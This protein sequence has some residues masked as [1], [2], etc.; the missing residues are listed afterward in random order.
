MRSDKWT[1]QLHDKL[2]E[3]ETPAPDGL[4]D[5][6]ESALASVGVGVEG[7]LQSLVPVRSS[8]ARFVTMRRWA[9]AAAIA[10]L[11]GGG[12]L[13]WWTQERQETESLV[14]MADDTATD[15]GEEQLADDSLPS[16]DEAPG[17]D[18]SLPSSDEVSGA[19]TPHPFRGR[20]SGRVSRPNT[21]IAQAIPL[22]EEPESP[23]LTTP[24]EERDTAAEDEAQPSQSAKALGARTSSSAKAQGARTSSSAKVQG[25]RTS[26]PSQSPQPHQAPPK[27]AKLH[28]PT[29]N[30][31]AMNSLGTKD[32]SNGVM[33]AD[34]LV[35]NYTN[36]MANAY[37]SRRQAPIFLTGFEERVYHYQPISFGLTVSYP[38]SQRLSL[39]S[40]VVYTKTRSDFTQIIRSQ[41][42]SKEQTLHYVGI[43]LGLSYRLLQIGA[44]TSPSA[45]K[46]GLFTAYVSAG[47]Q[48]DWN[49]AARLTTEGVESPMDRDRI[50][51]SANAC[52]GLQYNLMPQIALYAEPGMNHYFDNGSPVSNFFKDKPTSFRLQLGLRLNLGQ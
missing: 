4:W 20:V 19:E 3:H 45:N 10:A 33:M 41:Q 40:G 11:I 42:I 21:N 15:N 7:D 32:N 36:T 1:Q 46:Q 29:L 6:I 2:A 8:R 28:H 17:A 34:G 49:A 23:K 44:R 47:I 12:G 24:L 5:D 52:I 37:T 16:S 30:L 14:S 13:V 27:R 50:Q 31:Y 22:K 26:L 25:A 18:D 43:P 48:A 38:L 39:T 51:W 9:A 35:E